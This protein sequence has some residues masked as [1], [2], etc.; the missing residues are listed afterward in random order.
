MK[1]QLAPIA[2][3]LLLAD[4]GGGGST[5]GSSSGSTG[6]VV[7]PTV[8]LV[9]SDDI[10]YPGQTVAVTWWSAQ[11][12]D[13][14]ASGGWSGDKMTGGTTQMTV[15]S[16]L[17]LVLSCVGVAS[18]ATASA[19][20]YVKMAGQV[21]PNATS[22][23]VYSSTG[24]TSLQYLLVSID[25]GRLLYDPVNNLL[26]CAASASS[27]TYPSTLVSIDPASGQV[28]AS[29]PLSNSVQA[30]ALSPGS[31]YLYLAY[32]VAGAG[33]QRYKVAGLVPD[34]S[35]PVGSATD[36][37]QAVAVSPL[38]PTTIAVTTVLAASAS[39][40]QI[41]DA[42]T[43]RS[44][45]YQTPTN[46]NFLTPVWTPD[47]SELVVPESGAGLALFNVNAQGVSFSN[48]VPA[49]GNLDG[50]LYGSTFYDDVGNVISLTGPVTLVGQMPDFD[51]APFNSRAES[52]SAGKSFSIDFDVFEN[53][54]VTAFAFGNVNLID[55]IRI[56]LPSGLSGPGGGS[57]TAWGTDG[58]AWDEG[59][60]LVIA[61]GT[62][63]QS[64]SG[65]AAP[66]SLPNLGAGAVLSV[67][68]SV[69]NYSIYN[70][71]AQDLAADT[72]GGVYASVSGEGIY[73]GNSVVAFDPTT[74]AVSG[75]GFA[76]SEPRVIAVSHDCSAVYATLYG[77]NSVAG[78]SVPG[79]APMETIPLI[80][81][82]GLP[83]AKSLAVDP[84]HP[85]T[86]AIAMNFHGSLCDGV[87]Y[88]L[89]IFDG[90][91]ARGLYTESGPYGIKDVTWG[92][93]S[94][95][96]FGEDWSGINQ[97]V[98][99][100]SGAHSPVLL[101]PWASYNGDEDIYDLSRDLYFDSVNSR[102]L[103]QYGVVYETLA[104]KSLP[105]LAFTPAISAN[106][107]GAISS[108]TADSK[109]GKV[110]AAYPDSAAG[111]DVASF[112]SQTLQLIDRVVLNIPNSALDAGA[113][114]VR[115]VRPANSSSVVFLTDLGYVVTLSGAMFSP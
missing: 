81:S 70:F 114:A 112:D 5:S 68:G 113:G 78:L 28:V 87:D 18:T 42:V 67:Q 99:D 94:S 30:L 64:N 79:I 15:S 26:D 107:C 9:A 58:L 55:S 106:T 100:S 22:S 110:F 74:G 23:V 65:L 35:I 82:A 66:Q 1:Y 108:V 89:A 21:A 31:Q 48:I 115:L 91:T 93:D 88:G 19:T 103:S 49:G 98:V 95:T 56:N 71:S 14:T 29:T 11:A 53:V 34:I 25:C 102:L 43:A 41:I 10:V 6:P 96:L 36:Y 84:N 75:A 40:L 7:P 4:C 97:F 57:L 32:S 105:R 72:C 86:V 77:S 51:A 60:S 101:V 8:S 104:Q 111:I 20:V 37:V 90:V 16:D 50:R 2:S 85:E 24:L 76:G 17:A 83:F 54:S 44:N 69:V 61:H 13:C 59:G 45:S 3:L 33:V 47:G 73:F 38:S 12:S 109:T 92:A 27:A 80:A 52:P 62:F 63:A 39:E 46:Q